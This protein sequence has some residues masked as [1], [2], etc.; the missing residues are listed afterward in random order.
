MILSQLVK[1]GILTEGIFNGDTMIHT[2]QTACPVE[3]LTPATIIAAIEK[4]DGAT[5]DGIG[6][7]AFMQKYARLWAEAAKAKA[8]LDPEK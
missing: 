6:D 4:S 8:S 5:I 7:P 3:K 2:Y 1:A